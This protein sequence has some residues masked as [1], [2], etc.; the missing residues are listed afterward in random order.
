MRLQSQTE[1]VSFSL[2]YNMF[3]NAEWRSNTLG[4]FS[5]DSHLTRPQKIRQ[6]PEDTICLHPGEFKCEITAWN[7][8]PF[9]ISTWKYYIAD[10]LQIMIF[11][12]PT[13]IYTSPIQQD[14]LICV[15]LGDGG[16]KHPKQV[17]KY[18]L[19]EY[20]HYSYVLLKGIY[21]I[22][23]SLDTSHTHNQLV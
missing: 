20:P 5:V 10:Q 7:W 17:R 13:L 1:A 18:F 19:V 4:F 6:Y 3:L 16:F 22:S 14:I 8:R 23:K 15:G 2:L 12:Q 21:P 9:A 11:M